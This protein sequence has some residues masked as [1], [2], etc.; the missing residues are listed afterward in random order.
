MEEPPFLIR[1]FSEEA[2]AIFLNSYVSNMHKNNNYIHSITIIGVYNIYI[3]AMRMMTHGSKEKLFILKWW[4]GNMNRI[5]ELEAERKRLVKEI[6]RINLECGINR[7]K[8]PIPEEFKNVMS[9]MSEKLDQ[10]LFEMIDEMDKPKERAL[11]KENLWL[12]G[13]PTPLWGGSMD[14]DAAVKGAEYFGLENIVYVYGGI[15]DKTLKIHEKCA[16]LLC[17]LAS[18][19]RTPGAQNESNV[20]NAKNLSRLSLKFPNVKGGVIDDLIGNYGHK[21][22]LKEVESIRDALKRHNADLQLYAVIY[23]HELDKEA[24][25]ILEPCIDRVN[26][27]VWAKFDLPYLDLIVE[28]C[29]VTFPGKEIMMGMFMHD[30]GASDLGMPRKLLEF[31]LKRAE[32]YLAK[33]KINDLVILGDREIAKW[34]EAADVVRQFLTTRLP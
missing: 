13:G 9:P 6:L 15:S 18:I 29:R 12:W 5:A 21:I 7:E 27:W 22:S 30:Y 33:G 11:S 2:G 17:Q 20:E 26:L 28:K 10:C 34:P 23:A 32:K 8:G 31:Q 16:K 25:K 19:N 1:N 24:T 3:H 4:S 14:E